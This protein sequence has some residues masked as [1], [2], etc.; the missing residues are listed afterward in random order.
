LKSWAAQLDPF[1][2]FKLGELLVKAG[3]RTEA[4]HVFDVVVLF[5]TYAEVYYDG[6]PDLHFVDGIV[7]SAKEQIAELA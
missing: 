4:K 5:P 6:E 7:N 3:C 2:L 1:T